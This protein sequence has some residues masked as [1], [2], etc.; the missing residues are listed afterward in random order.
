MG[1]FNSN[2]NNAFN[3]SRDAA[4][5]QARTKAQTRA[6]VLQLKLIGQSHPTGLT[7]N[8]LKLFEPRAPLEYKPPPEK[9][10]CPSYTGMAQFVGKFAE[11]GDDE[12]SP[13]VKEG[14]TAVQ[15]RARVHK[16]R[17]EEGAKKAADE[18]EKYDPSNDPNVTGDPYKTLFVAR[19]NYET[20]EH[21]IKREFDSYGTVKRVRMITDKESN[22]P[23]GYAF[24]EYAH[25]R[26][27][28]AAYKQADGR[29]LD[30]KRVLVDVERGRTVPNWRPRRLGG[31][32]GSTRVGGE[33]VNQKYSGREPQQ[34]ASG[35]P[36]RSEEPRNREERHVDRDREKSRERGRDKDVEH[37][38]PR[39]RSHDR[40]RDRKSREDRH[41]DR[42]RD[43]DRDR[44]RDH[45]RTR[46]RNRDR[47]RDSE[48]DQ[49]R[50]RDRDRRDRPRDKDK[51]HERDDSEVDGV[52]SRDK[53]SDYDRVE[54]KHRRSRHSERDR[55]TERESAHGYD[56]M[57]PQGDR[58]RYD[59][60]Q[61]RYDQMEPENYE[62]VRATSES[63]ERERTRDYGRDY[64]Q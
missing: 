41:C 64:E 13:P 7:N 57:E 25:T 2:N 58:D 43:R 51:D 22:K 19:L 39:E 53:D 1:D 16:L 42:N 48:P 4:A 36:S 30:N 12:Y 29:K 33:E 34:V 37:E 17:L 14:E 44:G 21:R 38:K 32:L 61:D 15:R 24:I 23:R 3:R 50:E 9:R 20:T 35:G 45:D 55:E 26:D 31:G 47:V 11:P 60:E 46:D 28:K 27:M 63:R 5:V 54:S 10:K 49:D 59:A 6:S 40:P 8:L 52:R 56:H 18:L 62:D